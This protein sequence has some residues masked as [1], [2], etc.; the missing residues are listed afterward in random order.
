MNPQFW[1]ERYAREALAYGASPNGFVAEQA[2]ALFPPGAE[3]VELGAGEGRNAVFLAG[4]GYRV[5]VVDYA[6]AGL[7][8]AAQLARAG[9]VEVEIIQR[10]VT[11]WQPERL[12]D[13]AVIAFLHL[14]PVGRLRLYA[15]V[16]RMLRLG[17]HLIAVWFRPEQVT[18]GYASGGPKAPAMMVKPE[19]LEAHFTEGTILHVEPAEVLLDEGPYHQGPAAVVHFIWRKSSLL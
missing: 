15:L 18:G 17:G 3:V 1:N 7:A 14:P 5:T 10:D 4:E 8:K 12:W 11:D 6:E 19:E 16:Q 2:P 13:G 9:N